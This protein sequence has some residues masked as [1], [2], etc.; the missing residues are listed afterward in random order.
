MEVLEIVAGLTPDRTDAA[1]ARILWMGGGSRARAAGSDLL[2]RDGRELL[3]VDTPDDARDALGRAAWDIAVLHLDLTHAA[4][5]A[6]CRELC[7]TGLAVLVVPE[8]SDLAGRIAALELGIAGLLPPCPHPLEMAA[9]VQAIARRRE[10]S[11]VPAGAA[12]RWRFDL[13]LGCVQAPSGRMVRLGRPE[14]A[15]L[16]AFTVRPG[17]ILSRQDLSELLRDQGAPADSRLIHTR[18]S[19]LRLALTPCD[20]AEDLIRTLRGGGYL[21]HATVRAAA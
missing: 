18:V 9:H 20:G 19:R 6:L 16:R 13:G 7:A 8:V 2:R 11:S 17:R 3:T 21:L 1:P 12:P 5:M 15:L 4:H 10:P 14:S